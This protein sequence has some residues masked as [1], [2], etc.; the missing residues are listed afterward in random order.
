MAMNVCE[1][2][3]FDYLDSH[4]EE[5]KHGVG[6]VQKLAASEPDPHT[7]ANRLEVELWAYY[8]ERS[9]I[10]PAFKEAARHEGTQRTSMKSLA[11]YLIRLWSPP[12]PK[13]PPRPVE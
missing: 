12:R 2:R 10:V 3:V 9:G 11:E 4:A 5:K 6:T 1:Q 13:P 7:A 8:K